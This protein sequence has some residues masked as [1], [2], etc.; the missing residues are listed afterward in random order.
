MTA[1]N[2][3]LMVPDTTPNLE[4]NA[5]MTNK[6]QHLRDPQTGR[7]THGDWGVVAQDF[8]DG[9][10]E[11]YICGH[12]EL[13]DTSDLPEAGPYLTYDQLKARHPNALEAD[14]GRNGP[15]FFK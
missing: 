2:V 4:R 15:M 12:C 11:I 5:A 1:P 3:E 10:T 14:M 6:T 8:T 13:F 9:Y 7:Y